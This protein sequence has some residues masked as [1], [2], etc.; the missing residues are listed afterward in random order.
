[1]YMYMIVTCSIHLISSVCLNVNTRTFVLSVE[2]I[3]CVLNVP[4]SFSQSG[5]GGGGEKELA[6]VTVVHGIPGIRISQ[7]V[8]N[9]PLCCN[10]RARVCV[11]KLDI[12]VHVLQSVHIPSQ[13]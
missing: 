5:G 4:L 6:T 12:H 10:M 8:N 7:K 1:M 3:F 2:F 9:V 13:L 11:P